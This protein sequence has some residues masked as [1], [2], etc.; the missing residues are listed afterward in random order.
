MGKEEVGTS[1]AAGLHSPF[2]RIC[3][4][5]TD[6]SYDIY[7]AKQEDNELISLHTKLNGL[8]PTIFNDEQ[9]TSEQA[10]SWPSKVCSECVRSLA[11]AHRLHQLCLKSTDRLKKLL[12]EDSTTDAQGET[13]IIKVEQIYLSVKT[14]LQES[15]C[16]QEPSGRPSIAG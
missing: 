4:T 13:D 14:E 10:I 16:E 1:P 15:D 2:C 8:F 3:V 7:E 6:V 12:C 9:A 11:E 5:T